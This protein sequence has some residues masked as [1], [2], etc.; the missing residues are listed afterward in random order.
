[1]SIINFPPDYPP[2]A[3]ASDSSAWCYCPENLLQVM[4]DPHARYLPG[5][6]AAQP[7]LKINFQR[8]N[9]LGQFPDSFMP[10][11]HFGCT[12]RQHFE[13]TLFRF[14]LRYN[15]LLACDLQ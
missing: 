7:G 14:P 2:A 12:L 13:G 8:A 6:N 3:V 15:T 5:T 9:L 11:T 1:M 4:F 10:Y